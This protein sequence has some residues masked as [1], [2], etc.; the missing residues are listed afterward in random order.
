MPTQPLIYSQSI[1]LPRAT[2][3]DR[4]AHDQRLRES[5][6][7]PGL[8]IPLAVLRKSAAVIKRGR[9]FSCIISSA[10]GVPRLID[11]GRERSYSVAL[12]IGTTNL[13]GLLYDNLAA[14]DVAART[15]ENPQIDFG[16]DVL[17]RLHHTMTGNG[18][19]VYRVLKNGV[20]ELVS[21]LCRMAGINTEDIHALVVGGNT[22]MTH[23]FLGLDVATIPVAPFTPVVRDP[24][25][26]TASNLGIRICPEGVIYAFPNAG[27]YVGGDIT[28]GIIA[29]DMDRSTDIQL[30]VDVGTNAEIV[31]GNSDW[32]IV[33]AGAAGP[34]LEE[35]ISRIGKRATTGIIY[36]LTI[37]GGAVTCSTFDNAE[38]EGICGSGMISLVY[39]LYQAGMIDQTGVLRDGEQVS[40]ADGERT[41]T[42]SCGGGSPLKITQGEIQNFLR[43]KAAMFTLL[44]TL[45]RSVGVS[46]GHIARVYV[47][48]ALGTGINVKKAAAIG[49]V[50]AWP[51]E[52]VQAL[53][54]TSLAGCR[55]LLEDASLAERASALIERITY[56]HMHDDPEFMK[57]FRGAV[58]IPHTDPTLLRI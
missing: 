37:S 49:M 16:S 43:S 42:L 36:D 14:K 58:F 51:A 3:S 52:Q 12:D 31:I 29:A 50:P 21:G 35:G 19:E 25:F 48:G 57:E 41:L 13:A 28:A 27:S 17:T 54:N 7:L 44:L 47:S 46:F 45:T 56:K 5:L 30:L 10:F 1:S 34:A 33:G 55:M 38:P 11:I 39:E 40:V 9:P 32:M 18:E 53:G 20:N 8:H 2:D 6:G 24:G 26:R 22:I 15:V 4:R 23:F